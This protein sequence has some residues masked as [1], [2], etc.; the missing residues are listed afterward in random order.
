MAGASIEKLLE[1]F[2]VVIEWPVAWRDMDALQHVN[3]LSFL[4][5]FEHSRL[6]YGEKCGTIE[7]G[8]ATGKGPILADLNISYKKPVF[9]PDTVSVGVKI[10]LVEPTEYFMEFVVV[11]HSQKEVAAT[12]GC[13]NVFY[14]YNEGERAEIPEELLEKIEKVEGRKFEV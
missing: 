10:A 14:D 2:P 7:Y 12:G 11:S 4:E 9:Y 8:K 5:Y 3:S 6:V 1:G 13:R